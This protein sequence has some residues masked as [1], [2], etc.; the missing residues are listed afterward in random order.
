MEERTPERGTPNGHTAIFPLEIASA[1]DDDERDSLLYETADDNVNGK[2]ALFHGRHVPDGLRIRSGKADGTHDTN[3]F[4]SEASVFGQGRAMIQGLLRADLMDNAV[5][6]LRNALLLAVL[7]F[8]VIVVLEWE[9]GIVRDEHDHMA[10]TRGRDSSSSGSPHSYTIGGKNNVAH[11]NNAYVPPSSSSSSYGY[12]DYLDDD[13]DAATSPVNY[14]PKRVKTDDEILEDLENEIIDDAWEKKGNWDLDPENIKNQEGHYLHDAQLSPFASALYDV[15]QE[16]LDKRQAAFTKK[17][18]DTI[19][20]YGMWNNPS[21]DGLVDPGDRLYDDYNFRDVPIEEFPEGTWQT[22]PTYLKAH[23]DQAQALVEATKEGI[24]R[25]Y[26]HMNPDDSEKQLF[27]VIIGDHEFV[28]GV[29]YQQEENDKKKKLAH[30]GIAYMPQKSWD[31]LVKKLLHAMITTDYFYVVVAGTEETYAANNFAMTQAMQFNHIMEPIFHKLGMN[32]ISRNM[33]TSISTI[34]SALGGADIYGETDILWHVQQHDQEEAPGE[35]DLLQKQVIMSGERIPII[36]SP[37]WDE[38]VDASKGKAWVGNLQPGADVCDFTTL[39]ALPASPACHG[40][41][42]DAKSFEKGLCHV[43]NSVC[44]ENRTDYIPTTP[45]NGTTPG[46]PGKNYLGFRRH[47]LEARKLSM[48][49]LH[50]LAAAL[51]FWQERLQDDRNPLPL[52]EE[53]WHVG[54]DYIAIREQVMGTERTPGMAVE[55]PACEMLMNALDPRICHLPMR[56]FT[57]WTP[58]VVPRMTGLLGIVNNMVDEANYADQGDVYDGPNVVPIAWQKP[59]DEFD[60][61]M[62]A[63]A[64]NVSSEYDDDAFGEFEYMD[65]DWY[66]DGYYIRKLASMKPTNRRLRKRSRGSKQPKRVYSRSLTRRLEMMKPPQPAPQ[67]MKNEMQQVKK[68]P[69]PAPQPIKTPQPTPFPVDS[70]FDQELQIVEGSGWTIEDMPIGLCDG[71]AQSRCNRRSTN[72]CLL[73]NTN[74]YR[75]NLAGTPGNGWLTMSLFNVPHQIVLARIEFDSI[76][77]D[78]MFDYGINGRVTSL[79]R[80]QLQQFGVKLV[81]GLT[82]YPLLLDKNADPG[83]DELYPVDVAIRVR[84]ESNPDLKMRLSHI[85]YA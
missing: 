8:F 59:D 80:F 11:S 32:L 20:E 57:E 72:N 73:S 13:D 66:D 21:F 25:E 74:H 40:V 26:N 42:C 46:S 37:K 83:L 41:N 35:F 77:E 48:L 38:L 19:N 2:D 68:A 7:A 62:I 18:N 4:T 53:H 44:W 76:P 65:D 69:Q 14:P 64:A 5:Y 15:P 56:A 39:Q 47:Q 30:P 82:I 49:V 63:I 3:G 67:P 84:C 71:S 81:E 61:H 34:V 22:D 79:S 36:L 31:G 9:G 27:G 6:H 55:V 75:G 43:Y 52:A 70:F 29:A 23:L 58:R 85:Y 78:I 50:A 51:E 1:D 10:T 60:V 17:M 33:G 45:Q 28:N 16:E 12:D 24:M 54:E